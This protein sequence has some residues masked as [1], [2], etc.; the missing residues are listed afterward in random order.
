MALRH[1]IVEG[2]DGSGKDTLIGWLELYKSI[3]SGRAPHFV[4]HER[5]CTSLGGPVDFLDNWVNQ[6]VRTMPN[7]L[8]S[9][10][11]RHPLVS[12]LIY[13]PVRKV[14]PGLTGNFRKPHWVQMQRNIAAQNAVLVL[15]LP[16]L[17]R[18]LVNVTRDGEQHMP[19]VVENTTHI[20]QGYLNTARTWPGTV[21]RYNYETTKADKLIAYLNPII[22][23]K[24][25]AR[26]Y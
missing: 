15:C 10:Y 7:S 26:L 5:A 2:P 1:V 14:K 25:R 22:S 13:A 16:P 11:N 24:A 8:P 18:V 20:Y 17:E 21:M 4:L 12:E 6:D 23:A 3:E 9:I 19:G